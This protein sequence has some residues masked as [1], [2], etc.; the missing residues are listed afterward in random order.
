MIRNSLVDGIEVSRSEPSA[1]ACFCRFWQSLRV[2]H[3]DVA[4]VDGF[5]HEAVFHV[6]V[7]GRN[8]AEL[9]VG[10]LG[11]TSALLEAFEDVQ[12]GIVE[13]EHAQFVIGQQLELVE[14]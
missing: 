3:V 5:D 11:F 14:S 13:Q 8:D 1:L 6:V 4:E 9:R 12:V 2:Y 10:E 7:D